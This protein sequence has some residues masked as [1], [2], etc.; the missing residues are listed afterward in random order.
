MLLTPAST[1]R[2]RGE[3]GERGVSSTS[4]LH[5]S[6][7]NREAPSPPAKYTLYQTPPA[8]HRPAIRAWGR[9]MTALSDASAQAQLATRSTNPAVRRHRDHGREHRWTEPHASG[10]ETSRKDLPAG[11]PALP[12]TLLKPQAEHDPERAGKLNHTKRKAAPVP[13]HRHSPPLPAAQQGRKPAGS[14]ALP[15]GNTVQR[16]EKRP[17]ASRASCSCTS[18]RPPTTKR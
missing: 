10:T 9:T 6:L 17:Q 18:R 14:R 11:S 1:A 16:H 12:A 8:A 13:R 4:E 3:G 7:S 2:L 15:T 5:C